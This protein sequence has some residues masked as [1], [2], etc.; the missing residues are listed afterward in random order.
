M[1]GKE[2]REAFLAF[3][4]QRGHQRVASASLVPQSDPTLLFTNAGMV[5]FKRV[6]LG[7]ESRG[8]TRAVSS[9][10][11]MRVSGKHNDLEAVGRSPNHHTFFEML[12]NFSF[13]DYFKDEAIALAWELVTEGFGFSL[14]QL[15]VSVFEEDD[16][17]YAL[18]HKK[19]GL[20]E[21]KLY[22]LGASEN[23]WT[24]GETG[25][26]GPCTEIHIDFGK[27]PSCKNASCDPSCECGRWVEIWNLVFMQFN[28]DASGKQTPLPKPSV[29]TGAG[30]DRLTRVLQGVET[31]YDTDLFAPILARIQDVSRKSLGSDPELDV[32][33]RIV[34]DHARTC[35]FLIGDGVLPSNEGRG[36]VLR[37][38][39]RRAA[40]Q[41]AALNL[42]RPFL[43][44]VAETVVDEMQEAYPDLSERR[45]YILGRIRS[46][47]E[48]FLETLWKGLSLLEDEIEALA[49]ADA[50]EIPG[51]VV[52]KLYDTFG[53]PVDLTEDILSGKGI[54]LDHAGF[55]REMEAQRTRARAAWKGSGDAG[56]GEVYSTLS[57]ELTTAFC[58]YD[59]LEAA[60]PLR[61]ILVDG[62]RVEVAKAGSEVAL[63]VD[64]TPF[65]AESGGQVGDRGRITTA[66]GT[67]EV[68]NTQRP[69]GE[70]VVHLGKVVSGEVSVGETAELCVDG[71][72]RSA[73]VRNHSGTHLLHAALRE[74]LGPEAMQ[75]GSLVSPDRLRFDFTHDQP[76]SDAEL[77][78]IEDL[79]NRWIVENHGASVRFLSYDEAVSSGAVALFE[80]KYGDVVR[81]INFGPSTEL[82]G[83]THASAT[84]DIGLLRIVSETGIA[85]GVRRLEAVTG[86]GALAHV[87]GQEDLLRETAGRLR[88]PVAELPTRVEKL[89]EE[90]RQLEREL[91]R[92]RAESRGAASGDLVSEA[93]DVGGVKVLAVRVDDVNSKEL[94]SL[95]D[96]LRSKLGSGVVLVAAP[97][98][99][100]V[101]IALGISPD[102]VG[103]FKA[104]DLIREIASVLGGKGGGRP[105]FAQ[106]GG[107]DASQLDAAFARLHELVEAG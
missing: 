62:A 6:F 5:P 36:Y 47:E 17:A 3:F 93:R 106:A 20:P 73:T 74:V 67:V 58:G 64:E 4:E 83:G 65:Y 46:E 70:L 88:A 79:A 42:D 27:P 50:R 32:A 89:V 34:A 57:S 49:K 56:V 102:L 48:R 107:S 104:G 101:P 91:D 98:D 7:E 23:F 86:L 103:R 18:W 55:T 84:G 60:S 22:R 19:V 21:S 30:L 15:A 80:E 81:V 13:G 100:R 40:R 54:T 43:W 68:Q 10:K 14:D 33:M 26:C 39:L 38:I 53:F 61:A 59:T 29:D 69:S 92:L 94:R 85:S 25:P 12:G 66:G 2:V 99:G 45:A 31:N 16:E 37:R 78:Q 11:C 1:S 75:K 97:A 41:G 28:R 87:R 52:F 71:E 95:V 8:Y 51:E 35:T 44:E 72:T 82:C 96:D 105:D 9:Q 63:V 76:V 90:K 77:R 24:M